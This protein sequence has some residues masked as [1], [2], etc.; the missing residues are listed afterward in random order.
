MKKTLV[1]ALHSG[2]L[3]GTELMALATCDGLRDEYDC[4]IFAPEGAAL[5]KAMDMNFKAQSF[6]G[7]MD[8]AKKI[9]PILRTNDQVFFIATGLIHSLALIVLNLI[10]RRKV[11][12]LHIVHGGTDEHLS[13]G[14]KR[15]L[16]FFNVKFV[17]VSEFV[18]QRLI[19][20]RVR[21]NKITVVENFL[22]PER[23]EN[24]PKRS[25]F[26]QTGIQNVA[27]I[28]RVDPIKKIHLLLDALDNSVTLR[29][30]NF[31]V[32]GTGS[33]FDALKKRAAEN[34]PNVTFAGYRSD[35]AEE[36][37]KADLLLHLCPEEPFGL[38]IIEAFAAKVPVLVPDSGGAGALVTDTFDGFHFRADNLRDLT[39]KLSQIRFI[40]PHTLNSITENAQNTLNNRFSA[41]SCLANYRYLLNSK[42]LGKYQNIQKGA[43]TIQ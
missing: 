40:L 36:L 2:N 9:Q 3:Y 21:E 5:A 4:H 26:E 8:F 37:A 16:N 41:K 30:M 31:T 13:Y 12:H 18:K 35:V 14:R 33:E 27:V 39:Q 17:A 10:Y 29:K 15:Y 38:A 28:S 7:A 6:E 24:C 20:H 23:V 42:K 22:P 32:Y 43:V 1:Y 11:N 19:A 34:N 25:P